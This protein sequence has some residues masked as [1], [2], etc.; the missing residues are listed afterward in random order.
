MLPAP[1]AKDRQ[2]IITRPMTTGEIEK[3]FGCE[4]FSMTV[5]IADQLHLAP[6][7]FRE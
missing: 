6:K 3:H 1:L 2:I 4:K 7:S 5:I